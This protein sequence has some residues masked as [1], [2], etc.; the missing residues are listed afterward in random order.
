MTA[1]IIAASVML[2]GCGGGGTK[3]QPIAPPP[4]VVE[5]ETTTNPDGSTTVVSTVEESDV[6]YGTWNFVNRVATTFDVDDGTWVITY[7][8]FLDSFDRSVLTEVYTVETTTIT[9]AQGETTSTVVRTLKTSNTTTESK[10]DTIDGPE[11]SRRLSGLGTETQGVSTVSAYESDNEVKYSLDGS[12]YE[13]ALQKQ[14][15][16]SL[17]EGQVAFANF[18]YADHLLK[19]K[20][21]NAWERGWTGKGTTIAIFDSGIDTDHSEFAGKVKAGACFTTFGCTTYEDDNGHG[22]HVAGLAAAAYDGSGVTGVAYDADLIVAKLADSNGA[23]YDVNQATALEWAAQNNADVVNISANINVTAD[24]DNS[25]VADPSGVAGVYRLDNA[26]LEANGWKTGGYQNYLG[27]GVQYDIASKLENNDMVIVASAGNQGARYSTF[28][29]QFASLEDSNGDL[30]F[31]GRFISVGSYDMSTNEISSFS[32]KAG[33]ICTRF[34]VADNCIETHKVSDYYILAPGEYTASTWND[35]D[36]STLSGTSMSAPIVTGAVAILKQ[37]WPQM[38]ARNTVRLLLDTADKNLPGYTEATHGQGLLDLDNATQMQ[39][40]PS[41]PVTGAVSGITVPLA[42]TGS[43][44]LQ[45]I[46]VSALSNVM[47]VDEYERDF[48]VD[49]N[50]LDYGVDTRQFSPSE[51]LSKNSYMPSEF[52]SIASTTVVPVSNGFSVSASDNLDKISVNKK[53]D[54]GLRSGLLLE[55]GGFLG[56]KADSYLMG[57]DSSV[58]AYVGAEK[59]YSVGKAELF[60]GFD[61]ALTNVNVDKTSLMK[62]ASLLMSNTAK[63][64][65]SY[66]LGEGKKVGF[67]ASMPMAIT[68]GS[69]KFTVPSDVNADG[70]IVYSNIDSPLNHSSREFDLGVFYNLSN[71]EIAQGSGKMSLN[72]FGEQRFNAS[73]IESNNE[74]E[75]GLRL[76]INF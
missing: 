4:P 13:S 59:N 72:M 9:T 33:T 69:A 11:V 6:S 64:G 35:G 31:D 32:N 27:S 66:S 20:A 63:I 1:S 60:G 37:M 34:D 2:V 41:V 23:Y 21:P 36:Y 8:R 51:M 42:E 53:Y 7:Q 22:T 14:F 55:Q 49:V 5:E 3:P 15:N 29:A 71:K 17:T 67:V 26:V 24:Y 70:S 52:V 39:T 44:Q 62:D 57:V 43:I 12:V 74:T 46:S 73:N 76:N 54:S 65:A 18:M 68:D 25:I 16:N 48:Y 40:P 47:V 75:V 45:G 50:V 38:S 61:V 30:L 58:T 19:V 10:V 56:N 28:P